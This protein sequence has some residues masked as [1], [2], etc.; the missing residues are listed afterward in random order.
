[1]LM[2]YP[3]VMLGGSPRHLFVRALGGIRL[4]APADDLSAVQSPNGVARGPEAS[5]C[6]ENEPRETNF[7]NP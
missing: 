3:Q 2:D 1:M 7:W 4:S 6:E 5:G